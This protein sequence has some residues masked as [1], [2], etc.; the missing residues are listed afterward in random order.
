MHSNILKNAQP[1]IS[2]RINIIR[3]E[4]LKMR[5]SKIKLLLKED[6]NERVDLP[7]KG[8]VEGGILMECNVEWCQSILRWKLLVKLVKDTVVRTYPQT[9]VMDSQNHHCVCVCV[10]RKE[11]AQITSCL[12]YWWCSLAG[13]LSVYLAL[14]RR[15]RHCYHLAAGEMDLGPWH[16]EPTEGCG[17]PLGYHWAS[18]PP[19]YLF[20][21]FF[22]HLLLYYSFSTCKRPSVHNIREWK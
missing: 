15:Q 7:S 10:R 2:Q 17:A 9:T 19:I 11:S 3:Q 1:R 12:S 18:V 22:T 13:F 8:E 4:Y 21:I 14:W 6:V 16:T 20:S 5:T